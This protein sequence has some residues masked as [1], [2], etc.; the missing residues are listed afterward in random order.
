MIAAVI[1]WIAVGALAVACAAAS[2]WGGKRLM[3]SAGRELGMPLTPPDSTFVGGALTAMVIATSPLARLELFDWGVRL[4]SSAR[5]LRQLPL[6]VATWEARYEELAVV[7][8]VTVRGTSGLAGSAVHHRSPRPLPAPPGSAA[9]RHPAART[10][11]CSPPGQPGRRAPG[12]M[13]SRVTPAPGGP[14]APS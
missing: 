10:P 1:G 4:S 6:H 3:S 2:L 7:R 12:W 13:R 9:R 11:P 5:L 14:A 8:S